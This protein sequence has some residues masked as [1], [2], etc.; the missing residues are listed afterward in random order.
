MDKKINDDLLKFWNNYYKFNNDDINY[1]NDMD[2]DYLN[3]APSYK[4]IDALKLFKNSNNVIDYGCG[5][6]WASIIMAKE[7]TKHIKAID[8]CENPIDLANLYINK[9]KLNDKIDAL[10]IDDN[11]LEKEKN[12]SYDGFFSSNVIDVIPIDKSLKIIKEA[13]RITKK[14]SYVIFS[15]NYYLSKEEIKIRRWN[16]I[17][18]SVI[19]DGVLRLTS[20]SDD[21]WINIFKNYYE[22]INLIHYAWNEEEKE[23]RRL[24]ILKPIK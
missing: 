22:I 14:D 2:D 20:L 12:D 1:I 23:L 19:I 18:D 13:A 4:Q 15:L 5:S 7:G 24:F 17:D 9:F 3:V 16:M 10:L 11:W 6:A 8:L 21:E